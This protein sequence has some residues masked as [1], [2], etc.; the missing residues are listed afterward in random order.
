VSF[1]EPDKKSAEGDY[2][3]GKRVGRWT[4]YFRHGEVVSEELYRDGEPDGIWVAYS[5][6]RIFAFATCFDRGQKVWQVSSADVASEAEAR[7]KPCP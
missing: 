2:A 7:A 4:R 3:D 6:R 5:L 1:W